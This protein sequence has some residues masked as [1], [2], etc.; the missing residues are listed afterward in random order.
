MNVA[1]VDVIMTMKKMH[2]N[3]VVELQNMKSIFVVHARLNMMINLKQ[4]NAVKM[5][6]DIYEIFYT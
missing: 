5:R 3:V 4:R 2:K 6:V 1:V